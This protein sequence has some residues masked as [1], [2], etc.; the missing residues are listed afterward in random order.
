M[1]FDLGSIFSGGATG[2]ALGGPIGGAVGA[3]V[4]LLNNLFGGGSADQSSSMQ[5]SSMQQAQQMQQQTLDFQQKMDAISQR[6]GTLSAIERTM[7]E[8]IMQMLQ[9]VK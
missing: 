2:F 4:G 9:A 5:S 8:S 6:Y 1:S 7:H 3:G